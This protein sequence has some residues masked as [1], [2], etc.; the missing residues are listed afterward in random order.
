MEPQDSGHELVELFDGRLR[1]YQQKKGYRF[2]IDA[3]LL[4]SFAASRAS[5]AVIDLGTG[6]GILPV[7]LSRCGALT[8]IVG[9]EIQNDLA[10]LARKNVSYNNCGDRVSIARADLRQV[11]SL[12]GAEEFDT[13][14]TNPPFYRRDSGRINPDSQKAAARHELNGTLGDFLSAAAF[15]L[16]QTGRLVA[17]Y[18]SSRA[19]DLIAEMRQR[20]IEPKVLQCVHA[21][22][23]DPATMVLAEGVKGAGAELQILPPLVLYDSRGEYTDL[24]KAIF[25][26][27]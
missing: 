19:A 24:V 8:R 23:G 21:R 20:N 16:K 17:V 13:V 2:S 25:E 26:N 12:F 11:R 6:C 22:V 3:V 5:G 18:L 10:D 9:L 27:V 15:L 7:M 14:I 1:L 4:G